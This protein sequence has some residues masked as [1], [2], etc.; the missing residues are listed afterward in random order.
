[1]VAVDRQGAKTALRAY[2]LYGAT[3]LARRAQI[4]MHNALTSAVHLTLIF[5]WFADLKARVRTR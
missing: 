4:A 5:N 3:I 1:M 2:R